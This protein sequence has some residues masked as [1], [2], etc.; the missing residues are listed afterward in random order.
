MKTPHHNRSSSV[1]TCR[2]LVLP[3]FFCA[4]LAAFAQREPAPNNPAEAEKPVVAA[5]K[6]K[7]ASDKRIREGTTFQ[8]KHVFFQQAGSRTTLFAADTNER[9][10]CL[11]NLNLERI[12]KAIEERPGR[13]SWKIDGMFTEF[14]GENYVL[15]QRA[16]VS[17]TDFSYTQEGREKKTAGPPEEPAPAAQP[18]RP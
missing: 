2:L 15:I 12:L 8:G 10:V 1:R 18:V 4:A 5:E 16:V 17:P 3:I 11:E 13:R 9:Y 7:D 6:K 14:Q